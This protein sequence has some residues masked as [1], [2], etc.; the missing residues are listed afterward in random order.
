VEEPG[1]ADTENSR[2]VRRLVMR[3]V[4]AVMTIAMS[5]VK[6]AVLLVVI[7]VVIAEGK[8]RWVVTVRSTLP[9]VNCMPS[10]G[11]K[12]LSYSN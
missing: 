11:I 4:A 3:L 1:Y 6:G 2:I 10:E 9:A 7:I 8:R 12:G 5:Y